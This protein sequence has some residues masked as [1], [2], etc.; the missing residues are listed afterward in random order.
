MIHISWIRLYAVMCLSCITLNA[1]QSP[2]AEELQL[3][4]S[5]GSTAKYLREQKTE[6]VLTLN[7]MDIETK[8]ST[9]AGITYTSGD[10]ADDGSLAVTE[11]YDVLQ[12]E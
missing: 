9:F 2:A 4:R 5:P 11:R 1:A 12:S 3:K 10:K 7:G 6:Q 8:S